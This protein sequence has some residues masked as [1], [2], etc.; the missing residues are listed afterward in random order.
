MADLGKIGLMLSGAGQGFL[1]QGPA[2]QRNFMVMQQMDR[3]EEERQRKLKEAFDME[4]RRTWFLDNRDYLQA[5]SQIDPTDEAS[6]MDILNLVKGK[7]ENRLQ[8]GAQIQDFDPQDTIQVHSL[9]SMAMDESQPDEKRQEALTNLFRTVYLTD[10][11]GIAEGMIKPGASAEFTD[12]KR[13]ESGYAGLRNGVYQNIPSPGVNFAAPTPVAEVNINETGDKEW[14]REWAKLQARNFNDLRENSMK[15]QEQNQKLKQLR[16]MDVKTGMGTKQLASIANMANFMFGE[17]TGDFIVENPGRIES[18]IAVTEAMTNSVLNNATGPQTDQ[19]AQRIRSTMMSINKTGVAN[20]FL[21][22]SMEA[23]NN[24]AIEQHRF[25]QRFM[26]DNKD[27]FDNQVQAFDEAQFAW[28]EY[29]NHV[30]MVS[31]VPDKATGLP[32]FF[33]E[34]RERVKKAQPDKT[35]AEIIKAWR[36]VNGLEEEE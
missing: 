4:R 23:T 35:E 7:T 2:W 30:P 26:R 36:V 19:D 1:G 17:G 16:S 9:A 34:F 13:T 14:T 11:R 3:E 32:I 21:I 18:Y 25:V 6:A 33:S 27:N 15:A 20:D 29:K 24:R 12:I 22:R 28:N 5:L 8:A 31:S 10:Q